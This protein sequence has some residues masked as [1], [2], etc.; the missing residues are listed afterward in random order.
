MFVYFLKYLVVLLLL[1]FKYLWLT[2]FCSYFTGL[3]LLAVK[4]GIKK[5]YRYNQEDRKS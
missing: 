4:L 1:M 5:A 3:G 2:I